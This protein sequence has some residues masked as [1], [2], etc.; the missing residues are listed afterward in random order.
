MVLREG[1]DGVVAAERHAAVL[2]INGVP[3]FIFDRQ[4]SVSGAQ[5]IETF[6]QVIDQVMELAAA[7]EFTP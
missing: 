5:E 6:T 4:Y 2:G 1:Q 3:T 7:R